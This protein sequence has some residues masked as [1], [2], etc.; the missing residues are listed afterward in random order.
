L[1]SIFTIKTKQKNVS[2]IFKNS[3]YTRNWNTLGTTTYS[4]KLVGERLKLKYGT[5]YER[6]NTLS[7]TESPDMSVQ[8]TFP[9][10]TPHQLSSRQFSGEARPSPS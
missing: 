10:N 2:N 4:D 1:T 9:S 7:D 3:S 5:L 6:E 8:A